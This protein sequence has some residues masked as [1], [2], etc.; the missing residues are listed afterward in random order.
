MRLHFHIHSAGA[1]S[2]LYQCLS[3][4]QTW[5]TPPADAEQLALAA[6]ALKQVPAMQRRR[7]SKL[8][9]MLLDVAF[10]C[11]APAQCR[12]IF[13]SRHG[14]LNR[15]VDL[16]QDIVRQQPI[17]P[18]GF[19]QSVH[20]T[21]SGIFSILTDNRAPSTSIAAGE[22]TLIQALVE[23]YGQLAEDNAPLLLVFGD[24][25]VSDIYKEFTQEPELPLAIALQLSLC[26]DQVSGT[27]LVIETKPD[28]TELAAAQ[29]L[30]FGQVIHAIAS[31]QPLEGRLNQYLV[32][33]C[34]D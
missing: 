1:W 34:H 3:D 14:E 10:Q 13:A 18:I 26:Q 23:A 6:P 24:E 12:T 9:K 32:R 28:A 27:Q 31:Q 22:A 19:S 2:P 5:P 11:D 8:T 7:F 33:I 20:N 16:L 17:S 15:T 21:A 4:W 29:P 25:P 30:S